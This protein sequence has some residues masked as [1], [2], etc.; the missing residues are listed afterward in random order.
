MMAGHSIPAKYTDSKGRPQTGM[1]SQYEAQQL[2]RMGVAKSLDPQ[3]LGILPP[4]AGLLS[5]PTPVRSNIQTAGRSKR[6]SLFTR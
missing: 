4:R 5:G 2:V 3:T 6:Q 1:V